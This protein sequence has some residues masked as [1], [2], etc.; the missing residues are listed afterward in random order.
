MDKTVSQLFKL[1]CL[2]LTIEHLT[3]VINDK[4]HDAF[5]QS[6]LFKSKKEQRLVTGNLIP[7]NRP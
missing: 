3:F 4:F 6:K 7:I 2:D 1:H 5:G